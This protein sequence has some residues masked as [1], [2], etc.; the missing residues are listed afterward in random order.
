MSLIWILLQLRMME[1]IVT[2]GTIRQARHQ[3]NH[4]H[5][6]ADTHTGR[7][8]SCQ[9]T[10]SVEPQNGKVSHSVDLRTPISP[11]GLPTMHRTIKGSQFPWG[12][13]AKPLVSLLMPVHTSVEQLRAAK[14]LWCHQLVLVSCHF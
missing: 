13:I 10:N 3:S 9:P 14:V 6:Q 11:V 2:T 5:Q 1:V 12:K 7:I 8:P 4:R